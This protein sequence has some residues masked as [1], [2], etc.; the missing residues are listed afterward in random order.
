MIFLVIQIQKRTIVHQSINVMRTIFPNPVDTCELTIQIMLF[1]DIVFRVIPQSKSKTLSSFWTAENGKN[2]VIFK[3]GIIFSTMM[4][5]INT[6]I[7]HK[8][9]LLS[10]EKYRIKILY[11]YY[12]GE[13]VWSKV[14][15]P[16]NVG[17]LSQK[18]TKG[19]GKAF[20]FKNF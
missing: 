8:Y 2:T 20:S 4:D 7:T 15:K 16:L 9:R 1:N 6:A 11:H 5:H 13:S 3:F 17:V 14:R 12:I 19:E 18:S 10:T